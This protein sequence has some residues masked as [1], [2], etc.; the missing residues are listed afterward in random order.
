MGR[1]ERVEEPDDPRLR[2]FVRLRDVQLRSKLEPEAGLFLAEGHATIRRAIAAGYTLRAAVG[3]ERDLA[4]L[5]DVLGA[6]DA[7]VYELEPETLS[8][9]AGFPVHRGALASFARKPLPSAEELIA[10][11]RRVVVLEDLNDHTNVG[12]MFRS[13]AALGWRPVL[14]TPRSAD[15]LYRRAVRTSMGA[16]FSVPWTRIDW[17]RGAGVI[18]G[19]GITLAALTPAEGAVA[20]EAFD[21]PERVALVLGSEGAGVSPRWLAAADVRVRIPMHA[22]IDS[23]NVAAA[24]AIALYALGP[25]D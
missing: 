20:I 19:A 24:A 1:V 5:D 10:D 3:S 13:A 7:P 4:A 17:T 14:L 9:T 22:G 21:A 2:D 23:L 8:G 15:P 12:A 25:R 16:V 18:R 11:A 6:L